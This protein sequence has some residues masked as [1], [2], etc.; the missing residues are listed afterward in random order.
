[1]SNELRNFLSISYDEL[2]ELNLEAKAQRKNSVCRL[3]RCGKSGLS[4]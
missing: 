2:E 1:M 3:T 4:I